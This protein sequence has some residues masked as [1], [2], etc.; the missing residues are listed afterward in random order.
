MK[1][2]DMQ[3]QDALLDAARREV[4]DFWLRQHLMKDNDMQ[5][6]DALLD[7][8][9]REVIDFWLRQH[10]TMSYANHY[11]REP[12][13][14][15][16]FQELLRAFSP[17]PAPEP[18]QAAPLMVESAA[19]PPASQETAP[20]ALETGEAASPT[21]AGNGKAPPIKPY[22]PHSPERIEKMRA[23]AKSRHAAKMGANGLT[24]PASLVEKTGEN[25]AH[26]PEP[27]IKARAEAYMRQLAAEGKMAT[28]PAAPKAATTAPVAEVAPT[29]VIPSLMEA[30]QREIEQAVEGYI[31]EC[32]ALKRGVDPAEIMA[33]TG[34]MRSKVNQFIQQVQSAW[35]SAPATEEADAPPNP[36]AVL[37]AE[38]PSEADL[39]AIEAT[40]AT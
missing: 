1:D 34:W 27:E 9:R 5:A 22:K 12:M 6:Q 31:R 10:F 24:V 21:P 4:I 33:R 16:I 19:V 29:P 37:Y 23:L 3:A 32:M 11:D 36:F 18:A 25:W 26:L 17:V 28:E 8:A 2:N 38:E 39:E 13:G 15:L 35:R 30:P 40:E 7:A 20:S 14:R